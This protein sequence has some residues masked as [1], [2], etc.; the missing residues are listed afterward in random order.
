MEQE[1]RSLE[2]MHMLLYRAYHAQ[3]NYLRPRMA[4]LGLGPGQPKLLAYLAVHGTSTQHEMAAYFEVGDAAI[5]RMLDLL[6]QA[7][8]VRTGRGR[9]R[10]TKAVE[11]TAGGHDALAAWDDICDGEQSAMLAGLTAEERATLA[12]LLERIHAN[13]AAA[14]ACASRGPAA[15]R[16]AAVPARDTTPEEARDE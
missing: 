10:R 1:G 4:R 3:T 14:S 2:D 5:S 12:G 11:L 15:A 13:L 9:D 6:L 7:G 16:R 8:F